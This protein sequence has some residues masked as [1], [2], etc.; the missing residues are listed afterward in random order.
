MK[1]EKISN[2]RVRVTFNVSKDDF[3]HALDYAYNQVKEAVEVKG[4]RKG[5]VPM[6]VYINKFGVES[7][8]EEALNHVFHHKHHEAIANKE[9][10]L[11]GE[12]KPVV[13]FEKITVDGNFEIA[14][15]SA[16]KPEVTLGNY[17]GIEVKKLEAVAS[18]E[19]VIQSLDQL[20]QSNVSLNIKEDGIVEDGNTAV[21]DFEGFHDGV[22]FEGGKALNHELV[23]GSGQFIP[24]FEEQ[25]LGM[26]SGEEKDIN[27]TFPAEYHQEELA[28]QDAIFKIKLHEVKEEIKPELDDE[29][30]VSLDREEKTLADLKATLEKDIVAQKENQ[31]KNIQIAE[32]LEKIAAEAKVDIPEEMIEFDANQQVK[33]IEQQASQYGL[34]FKTYVSLTGMNEEDLL[35]QIKEDSAKRVL[36]SLLIEAVS[37]SEKFEVKQ[38]ELDKK[39][40]DIAAMY[41]MDVEEVKKHLSDDVIS[42]DIEFE[43]ALDF[44]YDNLTFN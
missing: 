21:F 17:K 16:I 1:I 4:F 40:A 33:N 8:Y 29:W 23:I 24:G 20:S 34:D 30:V 28:G 27:V 32:A 18:L 44:I 42:K 11:V 31:N 35:K 9:Y 7:L 13:D 43:K 3:D 22:P 2:N 6:N 25:M 5:N 14:L 36:N 37:I 15:E 26:K 41:Q 10:Q 19:E 39:Y 38:E 12:P